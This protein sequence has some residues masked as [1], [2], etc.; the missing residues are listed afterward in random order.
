[1]DYSKGSYNKR[2]MWQ[3]ILIYFVI[4]GIIYAGIY[5]AFMKPKGGYNYPSTTKSSPTPVTGTLTISVTDTGF[6]PANLQIKVGETVTWTNNIS[7]DI[8]V[9]SSPHPAHT[10]YPPLNLGAS[11]PGESK[12]LMFPTA[13]TYKYHNHL[14][15]S[16]YGVIIVQ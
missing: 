16:Q 10:D 9:A 2:P 3:W 12:T 7:S 11:K 1:M 13:G 8:A 6:S 14:N 15:P 5:Y 4:G